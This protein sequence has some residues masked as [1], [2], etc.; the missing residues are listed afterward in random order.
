VSPVS[1]RARTTNTDSG[2]PEALA[3]WLAQDGCLLDALVALRRLGAEGRDALEAVLSVRRVAALRA[4]W[5]LWEALTEG[6]GEDPEALLLSVLPLSV[7][8]DARHALWG[9]SWRDGDNR[10]RQPPHL[11]SVVVGPG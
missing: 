1:R 4:S 5:A 7:L 2:F 3:D 11:R 10:Q 9:C 8:E 6:D